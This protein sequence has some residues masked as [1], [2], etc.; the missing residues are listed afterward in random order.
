[1]RN[2]KLSYYRGDFRLAQ[3]HLDIL[4][5]ATTREIANDALELSLRIKENIA[6]DTL[7]EGL[8]DYARIELLLF[9]NKIADA[10]EAL[11][12]LKEGK[13]LAKT[14]TGADSV[15]SINNLPI[16][17]DALW[18]EARIFLQKGEF[19]RSISLLE[20]LQREFPQEVLAD[21]AMFQEAE[22]YERQ[23]G[24]KT[25]AMELYRE[26]LNKYPGSVFAAEAR[27]RYRTLRGDFNSQPAN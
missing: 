9:Q 13:V 1:L 21:D 25:K 14:S 10:L 27:K 17:D 23:L 12:H 11:N 16:L 19:E 2:A 8:R 3:E 6:F 18:L 26:F 20:Q 5:E 22:I 4:K 7:G 24:N 15:Y